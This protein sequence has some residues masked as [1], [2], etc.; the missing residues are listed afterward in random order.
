MPKDRKRLPLSKKNKTGKKRVA[1]AVTQDDI[2]MLLR[3][4]ELY[5][6]SYDFEAAEWFWGQQYKETINFEDFRNKYPQGS[7]GAQLFERF[8]SKFE[9]AGILIKNGSLDENLYFDRFGDIQTEWEN[10]KSVIYDIRKEWNYPRFRE[11]FE[12]L[13]IIG[14]K[15]SESHNLPKIKESIE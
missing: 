1:S 12:L 2:N 9:L 15:W 14:R 8:T 6:T 11:N 5:N 7:K 4:A 3:I 10:S 13:A